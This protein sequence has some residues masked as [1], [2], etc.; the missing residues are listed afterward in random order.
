[1]EIIFVIGELKGIKCEEIDV[2]KG[3]LFVWLSMMQSM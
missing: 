2:A 1:V 3:A